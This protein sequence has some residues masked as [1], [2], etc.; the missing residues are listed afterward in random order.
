MEARV[1]QAQRM[2]FAEVSTKMTSVSTE[3]EG[4]ANNAHQSHLLVQD[5][6]NEMWASKSSAWAP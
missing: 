4:L 2:V 6:K 3:L 1:V 5:L